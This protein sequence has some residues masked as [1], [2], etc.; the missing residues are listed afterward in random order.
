MGKTRLATTIARSRLGR[1]RDGVWLVELAE[2][3]PD[4]E[5]VAEAIA[6]EIATVLNLRLTGPA[7]PVD[8][9]LEH[10]RQKQMLLV[11]DNFEHLLGGV[12]S[13]LEIVQRCNAVQ[14]LVTS[15]ET[16]RIRAEWKFVL[17][18]LDYPATDADELPSDV[19]ELFLARHTQQQRRTLSADEF[20]A[21]RRICRMVEGLPLA[22]E[23]AAGLCRHATPRQIADELRNGFDALKT[24]LRDVLLRH[25]SLRIAL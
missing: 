6:A 7:R 13:V 16:L 12:Q 9:L 5:D 11:L 21:I 4:D 23:L 1:Y 14:L 22:I 8:Q 17:A 2:I 15:R 25:R 24:S 19:V 20:T 10:L 18:G 3:D